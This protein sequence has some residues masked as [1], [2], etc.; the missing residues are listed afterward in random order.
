MA[1]YQARV[2]YS[3]ITDPNI[4]FQP[5]GVTQ[6]PWDK[7]NLSSLDCLRFT[8]L[9]TRWFP[10]GFIH[11]CNLRCQVCVF[12]WGK[13]LTLWVCICEY[14][15][16]CTCM[17]LCKITPWFENFLIVFWVMK[18]SDCWTFLATCYIL[19][20]ILP[21]PKRKTFSTT[22]QCRI[23]ICIYIW[24]NKNIYIYIKLK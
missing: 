8:K 14:V 6:K 21:H 16:M 18:S 1:V 13:Q 4:S 7:N 11:I 2:F 9:R 19:K 20:D 12:L 24:E 5:S 23:C 3:S 17:C 15:S 10:C 22:T